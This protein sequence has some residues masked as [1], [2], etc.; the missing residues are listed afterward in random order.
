M[1]VYTRMYMFC[2]IRAPWCPLLRV[3]VPGAY[4]FICVYIRMYTCSAVPPPA[5]CGARGAVF[6]LGGELCAMGKCEHAAMEG[7][8]RAWAGRDGEGRKKRKKK[9]EGACDRLVFERD[10]AQ[11][12]R[13]LLLFHGVLAGDV[14][15]LGLQLLWRRDAVRKLAIVGQQQQA[16]GLHVQ[17]AHTLHPAERRQDTHTLSGSGPS[18]PPGIA[19]GRSRGRDSGGGGRRRAYRSRKGWGRRSMTL[20]CALGFCEHS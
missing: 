16:R 11:E 4:T 6:W 10:S 14:V 18:L 5:G 2:R 20:G 7:G 19:L 13:Y 15:H 3:A 9:E 8:G 12:G 1:R 17:A